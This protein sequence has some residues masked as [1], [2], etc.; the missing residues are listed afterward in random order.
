MLLTQVKTA[1]QVQLAG[2]HPTSAAAWQPRNHPC[3]ETASG[4][5]CP[6]SCRSCCA[7]SLYYLVA[8]HHCSVIRQVLQVCATANIMSGPSVPAAADTCLSSHC[9]TAAAAAA[10]HAVVTDC[11]CCWCTS[12]PHQCLPL[13]L[14]HLRVWW[15]AYATAA[16]GHDVLPRGQGVLAGGSP[17]AA[18]SPGSQGHN[19]GGPGVLQHHCAGG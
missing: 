2:L 6:C 7:A 17:R 10:G 16:A 9:P 5:V 19:D 18:S 3:A 14:L 8:A 12:G 13:L 1:Q 15:S 4:L 11:L